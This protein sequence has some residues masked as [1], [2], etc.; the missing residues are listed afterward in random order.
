[1][2]DAVGDPVIDVPVQVFGR[3]SA[4][5]G[6]VV[7]S[8]SVRTAGDGSFQIALPVR[9]HSEYRLVINGQQA[10]PLMPEV[11]FPGV[12]IPDP[13][14]ITTV[15][16]LGRFSLPAY[17]AAKDYSFEV[18]GVSIAG[19]LAKALGARVS[20]T[21]EWAESAPGVPAPCQA[22][23][24]CSKFKREAIVDPSGRVT[25]ALLPGNAQADR[26]YLVDVLTP[27]TSAF[28]SQA[29]ITRAVPDQG[30]VIP[31][32]TLD[33][34]TRLTGKVADL[35]GAPLQG[36][37]VVARPALD[38]V[39]LNAAETLALA[40]FASPRALSDGSDG[41]FA[42]LVEPRLLDSAAR[43][44]IELVP[45]PETGLPRWLRKSVVVGDDQTIVDLMTLTPPEP[46]LVAGTVEGPDG[47]PVEHVEVLIFRVDPACTREPVGGTPTCAPPRLLAR[48]E[49]YAARKLGSKTGNFTVILSRSG[50]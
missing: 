4:V 2:V 6:E 38:G 37:E 11:S 18:Q 15:K 10:M 19:S 20:F 8:Q 26:S 23:A 16:D 34:K 22:G 45:P 25:V 13:T 42:V 46:V 12:I 50:L 24:R 49:T 1:V 27:A 33:P 14:D 30:G 43:Y 35:F 39:R 32:I 41:S 7:A 5:S 44:D 29:G 28:A 36:V 9:L 47:K 3:L 31:G 21:T 48:T 40:A 17:G